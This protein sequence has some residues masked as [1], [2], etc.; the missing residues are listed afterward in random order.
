MD[1]RGRYEECDSKYIVGDET[2][3]FSLDCLNFACTRF[4]GSAP[5]L[6]AVGPNGFSR[7]FYIEIFVFFFYVK[8]ERFIENIFK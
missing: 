5:E 7:R 8:Y 6:D 1:Y 3:Y 2:E 4:L